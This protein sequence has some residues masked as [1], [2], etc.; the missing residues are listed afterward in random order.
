MFRHVE[1][2]RSG[3]RDRR[4]FRTGLTVGSEAPSSTPSSCLSFSS[5]PSDGFPL[6]ADS[7]P[8]RFS[9]RPT[10]DVLL[11]DGLPVTVDFSKGEVNDAQRTGP[12]PE[13]SFPTDLFLVWKGPL[14]ELYSRETGK[15]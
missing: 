12:A 1:G 6:L 7:V 8:G 2:P 9:G 13:V 11:P 10:T 3:R 4:T 14:V 5:H 15:K